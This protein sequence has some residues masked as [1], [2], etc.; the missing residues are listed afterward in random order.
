MLRRIYRSSKKATKAFLDNKTGRSALDIGCIKKGTKYVSF[1]IF[2]TLIVRDTDVP[3]RVFSIM[4]KKNNIPD[5]SDRRIKAEAAAR[6]A[7][8]SGEVDIFQ[9][10]GA[11]EGITSEQADA[12]I[13]GEIEAELSLC[14]ADPQ[15]VSFFN[16]VKKYFGVVLI[17]DMYL[18]SDMLERLLDSCGI[19]G[20]ERLYISCEAGVSKRRGGLYRYA[21]SDLGIKPCELTHIGNDLVADYLKARQC[22]VNAVKVITKREGGKKNRSCPPR[23]DPQMNKYFAFGNKR[24]GPFLYGFVRWLDLLLTEKGYD[25]VYFFSRDGYMMKKAF[26]VISGGRIESHY[27]YFSRKSLCA[28]LVHY[29]EGFEQTLELLS[30]E[31]YVSVGKILSLYGFEGDEGAA[32][33][34]ACGLCAD[35]SFAYDTLKCNKKL[36]QLYEQNRD[37]INA[38]SKM[39]DELMLRY[40]RQNKMCGKTAIVDIGWHGNMQGLLDTFSKKHELDLETEG[41]YIGIDPRKGFDIAVNGYLFEPGRH[42]NKKRILCFLGGYE[43]LFQGFEGS[44]SGYEEKGGKVSA[45]LLRYEYEGDER[46]VNAIKCW[47]R[48]ALCFVKKAFAAGLA[49]S[50]ER[51]TE[52]LIRFGMS[53]S[54]KDTG[55]FE[56]FYIDDG[57]KSFFLPTKPLYRFKPREYI[58]C[59]ADSPWKTGF[60]KASFKFPAPYYPVY[61]LLK[62]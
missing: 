9:I 47:Q 45:K 56:F 14:H 35:D 13:E 19:S 44:T 60:M 21:L 5:F 8:K 7:S 55:L 42:R 6:A 33:A 41:F 4:E 30:W 32:A 38:R 58:K 17:S 2:D 25:R 53:P 15:T 48:G 46:A 23:S 29:C 39:Q 59:L 11:F 43:K 61:C 26:D 28:P 3:T 50:D 1:D 34:A 22:G 49:D 57:G 40:L 31:R 54:L 36:R 37:L 52:P 18:P 24:F 12:L 27:V 51:L 10:Y 62:K 20:Y 16:K